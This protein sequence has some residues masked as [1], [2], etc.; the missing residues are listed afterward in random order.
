MFSWPLTL[1]QGIELATQ[2]P[3]QGATESE[4]YDYDDEE[5]EPMF[6]RQVKLSYV[7][8]DGQIESKG[9]GD[10]AV[11]FDDDVLGYRI[12]MERVISAEDGD[13]EVLINHIICRE[14]QVHR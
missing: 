12:L 2:M 3:A 8:P 11:R 6:N 9:E 4:D 5:D 7:L 14:H 10:L 13:S 1:F